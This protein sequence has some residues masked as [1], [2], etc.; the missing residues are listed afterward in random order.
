MKYAKQILLTVLFGVIACTPLYGQDIDRERMQRDLNIMESVLNEMF[1]STWENRANNVQ[2]FR[3]GNGEHV[4]GIYI[5]DY[6]V[7]FTVR[8]GTPSIITFLNSEDRE[9]KS[10]S[11]NSNN[12]VTKED[13]I[14]RITHFLGNYGSTIGQLG[15]NE[16]VT[17]MFTDKV[18]RHSP[19][20][21]LLSDKRGDIN[22]NPNTNPLPTILVT[23]KVSDLQAYRKDQFDEAEFSN[24]LNVLT[25]EEDEN[26]YRDLKVM[27]KILETSFEDNEDNSF[28]I[29]GSVNYTYINDLGALFYL[30]ASYGSGLFGLNIAVSKIRKELQNF[31]KSESLSVS[32]DDEE[33][34][35]SSSNANDKKL[36]KELNAAYDDFI[37]T[38]KET[39]V[40]Y[41]RTLK[42]VKSDE[43]VYVS[44][45]LSTVGDD[46]PERVDLQIKKSALDAYDKGKMSREQAMQQITVQE[47]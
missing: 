34:S 8:G 31:T 39:V 5:E 45:S 3:L 18:N 37:S 2:I 7:L 21:T 41:G 38:L 15:S 16:K 14:K 26:K 27:A 17:I 47:Y 20:Y 33:T 13:I 42:S 35:L 36:T 6:G 23:A 25:I 29:R 32:F 22:V 9:K 28:G 4:Q 12:Q 46:L 43:Q 30:D 10:L 44:I 40:D 19:V 24:R 11:E 1:Q